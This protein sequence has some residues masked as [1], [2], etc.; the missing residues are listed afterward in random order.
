[1]DLDGL[2]NHL[3]LD[4]FHLLGVAGGGF[5]AMDYAGRGARRNC[6]A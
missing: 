4:K 5:I 3:K 1:V 6:S 2:I